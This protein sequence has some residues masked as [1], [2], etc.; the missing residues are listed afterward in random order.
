[1]IERHVTGFVFLIDQRRMAL[2]ETCR[3]TESWPDR[4]TG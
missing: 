2:A 4:R 1:M 3:A